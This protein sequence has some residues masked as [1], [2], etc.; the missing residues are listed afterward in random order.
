MPLACEYLRNKKPAL[1]FENAGPKGSKKELGK[2]YAGERGS[3]RKK[4][5]HLLGGR[6]AL[7]ARLSPS[8]EEQEKCA[9]KA[10]CTQ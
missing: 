2:D 7:S 9:V 6:D 4:K 1:S 3:P 8:D 10:L 5:G